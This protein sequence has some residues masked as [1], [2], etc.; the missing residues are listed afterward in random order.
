MILSLSILGMAQA[1]NQMI[2]MDLGQNH[3]FSW[4]LLAI[5]LI[6]PVIGKS[7]PRRQGQKLP[8]PM[9]RDKCTTCTHFA[10]LIQTRCSTKRACS[11][12]RLGTS[13]DH[14]RPCCR[15]SFE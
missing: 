10:W 15:R 6:L 12:A 8:G 13:L 11:I 5:G 1:V 3:A 14:M 9:G 7:H 2:A 4:A